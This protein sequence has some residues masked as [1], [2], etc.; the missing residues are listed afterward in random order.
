M[1]V[2]TP[3]QQVHRNQM[4]LFQANRMYGHPWDEKSGFRIRRPVGTA[5][6]TPLSPFEFR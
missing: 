3:E 4:G 2:I 5:S 1:L 6:S